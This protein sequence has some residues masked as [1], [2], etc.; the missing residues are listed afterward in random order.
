[1]RKLLLAGVLGT[2]VAATSCATGPHHDGTTAHNEAGAYCETYP[3]RCVIGGVVL[4]GVLIALI[5][6]SDDGN[7]GAVGG[8]PVNPCPG[9]NASDARLKTDIVEVGRTTNKLPVYTFR[10][11]G[12]TERF[13]GVL[14]QDVL[15]R[16]DLAHAAYQ[17]SDG[18]YRVDYGIL[19]LTLKN[20]GK[21]LMAG[22]NAIEVVSL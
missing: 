21:M 5:A 16:P 19:G 22:E 8:G 9:C 12:G 15:D 13:S 4:A 11:L 3:E 1:M 18:Y 17:G 14:A 6:S 20:A 2:S 10:Y 7:G